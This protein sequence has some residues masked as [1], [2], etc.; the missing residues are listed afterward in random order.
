MMLQQKKLNF[1]P[2]LIFI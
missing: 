1:S 2:K